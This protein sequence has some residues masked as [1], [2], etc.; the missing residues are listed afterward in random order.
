MTEDT[1]RIVGGTR[2]AG[3][4]TLNG[5]K[6][7]TLP[8]LAATLLVEGDCLLRNVPRVED[9]FTMLDILRALGLGVQ[10]ERGD[11]LIS[12][13]G[14]STHRAPQA[15]VEKMRASFYVFGPLLARLGQAE[16]PMPGGCNLGSRPVDYIIREFVPL[17]AEITVE[18]GFVSA[19][20]GRLHG[21]A[22]SLDPRYRSPGAT[23]NLVMGAVLAEGTTV[24]DNA[25]G[26][27]DV[28]EFC[29]FLNKAGA[30]ITGAGT[31]L[32]QVEGVR[33][34]SGCEFTAPNDRLEAGTYLIGAA[35]TGGDVTVRTIQPGA[36][37]VVLE[38]LQE[39][40]LEIEVGVDSVRGICRQRPASLQVE[41]APYPGFPTDL[42]PP[43][44]AML[45]VAAGRSV[46][47]E[48]IY[49]GRLSYLDQLS[50]MGAKCRVEDRI[51]I[52][53][54]VERLT[55]ARVQAERHMRAGAALV[56]A[57]LA[58]EGESEI[59]GRHFI[60]RGY[61]NFEQKLAALGATVMAPE[62]DGGEA[63]SA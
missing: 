60:E 30:R 31:P 51:A 52:I 2:L 55:G 43:L 1:I 23:F 57:A 15:L 22:I 6:N 39:A 10:W 14:I 40:G 11:L 24:I 5:S 58:A 17:G 21:G 28:V 37:G 27:P 49:D 7:G 8:L 18:H 41:T 56:L 47:R 9:V 32:L 53:E 3:T 48:N 42:Q 29:E 4:V 46:I 12:N 50:R 63:C 36:L 54:G 33:R 61:Q 13:R 25:C 38:K 44:A 62:Q 20:A 35:I 19:K 26:E 16:V 59:V 34:L 45:C